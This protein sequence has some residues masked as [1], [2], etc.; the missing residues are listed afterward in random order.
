MDAQNPRPRP[1]RKA[2]SAQDAVNDLRLAALMQAA[3]DGDR[4]AYA[5]LLRDLV[6]LLQRLMRRRLGFLQ[7]TDR[8][9]LTQ[10]ILLSLHAGRATYDPRRPFTPW[11]MGIAHHRIVDRARRHARLSANELLVDEVGESVLEAVSGPHG[12]EYGDPEQVRQAVK[13][14]PARQRTAIELLK[15]RDLSLKEAADVSGMSVSALRVAVHRAIKSLR[16]SLAVGGVVQS[17]QLG[18]RAA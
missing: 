11:V 13:S 8:E 6:P 15:L 16:R 12:S 9:D 4:V 10:D 7:P 17:R 14:L 1:L 2:P 18:A 3:Q 5:G